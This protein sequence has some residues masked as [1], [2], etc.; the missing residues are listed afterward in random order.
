M[1]YCA[2]RP[3]WWLEKSNRGQTFSETKDRAFVPSAGC[4]QS[5]K[6][7]GIRP[8]ISEVPLCLS[9]FSAPLPTRLPGDGHLICFLSTDFISKQNHISGLALHKCLCLIPEHWASSV[10]ASSPCSSSHTSLPVIYFSLSHR[11]SEKKTF[12]FIQ[13]CEELGLCSDKQWSDR[14]KDYHWFTRPT[15]HC[16]QGIQQIHKDLNYSILHFI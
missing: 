16:M 3:R 6:S 8:L 5:K 10:T 15:I 9:H 2:A 1:F 7:R 4:R 13:L 12:I 14:H 11:E